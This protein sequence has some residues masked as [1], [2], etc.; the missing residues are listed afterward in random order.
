MFLYQIYLFLHQIF[1]VSVFIV[2][3]FFFF[4][5][6]WSHLWHLKGPGP[7]IKSEP[8]LWP[9]PQL[10]QCWILNHC[11]GPGTEPAS[12]QRQAESLTNC[13][14]EGTPIAFLFV[15]F[16]VFCLFVLLFRAVLLAYK[17][18]QARGWIRAVA[19]SLH[20]STATP[21]LSCICN[22]HHSSQ[23]CRIPDPLSEAR[24]WTHIFMDTNRICFCCTTRGTP[25]F[26]FFFFGC[27]YSI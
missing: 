1:T 20:Y 13:S 21:D 24:D 11:T 27:A 5:L 15:W 3:L 26:W 12:P 6:C 10:H 14:P 7:A 2:F 23:Q 17:S 9:T 19:A 8:E 4:F 18:S 25:G 16:L 22:L